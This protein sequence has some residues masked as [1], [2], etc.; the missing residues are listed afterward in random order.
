VLVVREWDPNITPPDGSWPLRGAIVDASGDVTSH[1]FIASDATLAITDL[2]GD[3]FIITDGSGGFAL[4]VN[5]APTW[6][7]DLAAWDASA[8]GREPGGDRAVWWGQHVPV[9]FVALDRDPPVDSNQIDGTP[10]GTVELAHAAY[11]WCDYAA[12]HV[13]RIDIS[14]HTDRRGRETQSLT[15]ASDHELPA[16]TSTP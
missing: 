14:I 11:K 7:G 15:R 4:V 10:D 1:V 13:G 16:C 12:C 3:R 6:Y 2:G 9:A 5:G 8:A